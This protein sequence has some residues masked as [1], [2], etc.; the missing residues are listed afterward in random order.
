VPNPYS[1]RVDALP[2]YEL[3]NRATSSKPHGE[4]TGPPPFKKHGSLAQLTGVLVCERPEA[5]FASVGDIKTVDKP[6]H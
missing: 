6:N 2:L 1:G 3:A 5:F 4:Q